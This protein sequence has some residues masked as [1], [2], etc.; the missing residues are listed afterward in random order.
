MLPYNIVS[1]ASLYFSL[2]IEGEKCKGRSSVLCK[3]KKG[4]AIRQVEPIRES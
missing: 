1:S 4:T 2:G 3:K